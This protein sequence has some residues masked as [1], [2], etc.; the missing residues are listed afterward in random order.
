MTLVSVASFTNA[1]KF[2]KRTPRRVKDFWEEFLFT[3]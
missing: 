1:V 2:Y 3:C